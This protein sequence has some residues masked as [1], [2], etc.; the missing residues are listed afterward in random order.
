MNIRAIKSQGIRIGLEKE[1]AV[2]M[3]WIGDRVEKKEWSKALESANGVV[4]ILRELVSLTRERKPRTRKKHD[5][6]EEI[7]FAERPIDR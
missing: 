7:P 4:E 2:Q 1:L 6:Q 3:Q 5:N